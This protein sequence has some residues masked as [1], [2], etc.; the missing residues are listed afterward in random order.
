MSVSA[1]ELKRYGIIELILRTFIL[2]IHFLKYI[3]EMLFQHQELSILCSIQILHTMHTIILS[4]S[5]GQ[6]ISTLILADVLQ[7]K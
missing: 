5:Y 3:Y 1:F 7:I 4:A 2:H 6:F